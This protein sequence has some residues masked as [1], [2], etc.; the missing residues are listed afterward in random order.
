[1]RCNTLS[2]CVKHSM[3]RTPF[4]FFDALQGNFDRISTTERI[5]NIVLS[6]NNLAHMSI[7]IYTIVL[8]CSITIHSVVC[9]YNV[10]VFNLETEGNRGVLL[11]VQ[12]FNSHEFLYEIYGRCQMNRLMYNV[13]VG[14][15]S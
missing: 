11:G 2:R 9:I 6:R 10:K 12:I 4:F 15:L 14:N 8:L 3:N 13:I 1:M 5:S 7:C